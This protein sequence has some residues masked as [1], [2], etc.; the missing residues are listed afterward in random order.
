MNGR[1]T[2]TFLVGLGIGVGIGLL[3]APCSGEE[4]REWIAESAGDQAKRL[5]RQSRRW[6]FQAQDVLDKGQDRVSKVLK[7]S[8]SALDSVA[9]RL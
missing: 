5:R 9:A 8:R 6:V 2:I 1:G 3:F 4:A 7:T